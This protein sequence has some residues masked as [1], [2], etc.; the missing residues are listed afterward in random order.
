MG[1]VNQLPPVTMKS[2]ADYSTPNPSCSSSAMGK[3]VFFEFMDLSNQLKI[4]NFS[5]HMTDVIRQKVEQ[6]QKVSSSMRNG[7][8]TNEKCKFLINRFLLKVNKKSKLLFNEAIHLVT[9]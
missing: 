1:D 9:Q 2:I 5:F 8:L 3:I 6:F 7:T 4:N